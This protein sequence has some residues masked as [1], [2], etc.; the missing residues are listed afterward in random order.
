MRRDFCGLVEVPVLGVRVRVARERAIPDTQGF[1]GRRA[2]S[3]VVLLV[4]LQAPEEESFDSGTCK[5]CGALPPAVGK[6][7]GGDETR[8]Q[9]LARWRFA[10]GFV[11][12]ARP[13]TYEA[14]GPRMPRGRSSQTSAGPMEAVV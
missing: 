13:T 9:R 6:V 3:G 4:P 8:V 10:Y 2:C 5:E 14:P 1:D 12:N 7:H 11:Y